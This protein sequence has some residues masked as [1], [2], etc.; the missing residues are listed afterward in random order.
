MKI[1]DSGHA[2]HTPKTFT[3]TY[4]IIVTE[5]ESNNEPKGEQRKETDRE[6]LNS[7]SSPNKIRRAQK[8]IETAGSLVAQRIVCQLVNGIGSRQTRVR[9]K[10]QQLDHFLIFIDIKILPPVHTLRQHRQQYILPKRN[11]YETVN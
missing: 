3:R 1:E 11:L 9:S 6:H 5:K 2:T 10:I 8:G 4:Y 7:N